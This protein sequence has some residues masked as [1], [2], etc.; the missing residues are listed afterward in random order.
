MF[1]RTLL[2]LLP[3]L[4]ALC[5]CGG[6]SGGAAPRAAPR[7]GNTKLESIFEAEVQL[8]ADPD[9]TLAQLRR[10]GVDRVRVYVAWYRIAPLPTS[11]RPPH[12]T[13][14]D[15]GAYPPAGWAIYDQIVKAAQQRGVKP[16]FT[17]GGP[18][19]LWAAGPGAPPGRSYPQWRPSASAYG[20]FVR[21]IATRYSGH[22]TPPGQSKP[23]PRVAFW[24]VWNEPNYGPGLAPQA[25][26]QST[27]EVAPALYRGLLDAAWTALH[28][29]GH[30]NDTFLIGETAPRGLTTGNNP[31]SFSG[32]VPLRFL[33]ALY[34]VDSGFHQLRGNAATLR[35]CP[36]GEADSRSFTRLH[37]ALF[38]AS[39]F[40]AH[41]YPQG[42]APN[43][44]IAQEPDYADLAT[45][46]HLEQTLDR[47]QRTYGSTRSLP[48]WNTEFGYQTDPPEKIAHSIDPQTAARYLNWSEY[49]SWRDPRMRSYDQ[50]Q[51]TDPPNAN[52]LGGFAT[53]LEFKDGAAK[54]TLR[55]Y[56]MPLFLPVTS[57]SRGRSLEVWGCV[58]P[59]PDAARQT[60]VRQRA[61]IELATAPGGPFKTIRTVDLLDPHGYFDVT[62]NFPASG[63]VRLAWAEPSGRTLHSRL[64]AISV[65]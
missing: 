8:H 31:G 65:R 2:L 23:L 30:G 38:A 52:A 57:A 26:D 22:Y 55:A 4:T 42:L 44:V 19:P 39:G 58:R 33:R 37:P 25:I 48:I 53:G 17:L 50:Y 63:T 56:R 15:P 18:P 54:D 12:F 36:A 34:C 24:S 13:A 49:I 11:G 46:P 45:L 61:R 43:V 62:V 21:A 60:G 10:L 20:A 1:R 40:A 27:V 47:L 3:A 5:G 28:A 35:G 9:A 14:A 29:T 6:Q 51:L 32:M 64:Q 41:L 59:A 16:Y 7:S